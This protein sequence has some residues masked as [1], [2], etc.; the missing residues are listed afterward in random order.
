MWARLETWLLGDGQVPQLDVSQVIRGVG[1]RLN[2]ASLRPARVTRAGMWRISEAA[3]GLASYRVHGVCVS[4]SRGAVVINVEGVDL[5]AEPE[6][7]RLRD[8]S[9]S[10]AIASFE[11][12][13]TGSMA[14]ATGWLKLSARPIMRRSDPVR[15]P[16]G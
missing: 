11:A 16:G 1:L 2:C 5:L 14:T 10:Q 6:I 4:V 15:A 9:S 3:S 8:G 12:V 7:R 13:P